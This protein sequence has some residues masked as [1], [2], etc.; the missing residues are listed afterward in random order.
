MLRRK[1]R[2]QSVVEFGIIAILF[3][4][5]LFAIADFGLL[6][7]TWLSASSGVR[8]LARDAAVGMNNGDLWNEANALKVTGVTA[9]PYFTDGYCCTVGS[10]GSALQITVT[11]WIQCTP[12]AAACN[13]VT[14][15]ATLKS[16]YSSTIPTTGSLVVGTCTSACAH[17]APPSAPNPTSGAQNCPS[18]FGNPCPGDSVTVTLKA[19]GA[20]VITPLVRPFFS[21]PNCQ[22]SSP[23]Y[24]PLSS[25]V[26]MRF[27]GQPQ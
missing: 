5:I 10:P 1:Q 21:G 13:P 22:N 17:P 14:D 26:T 19:A 15:A 18:G 6:L 8:L 16:G 25:S 4:L 11:Y 27:E 24:V 20:Q 2:G 9:D 12:G 23:C 3:T 7:N